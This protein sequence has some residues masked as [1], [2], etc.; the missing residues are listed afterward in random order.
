M[1]ATDIY[2]LLVKEYGLTRSWEDY[3]AHYRELAQIIYGERSNLIGKVAEIIQELNTTGHTVGLASSSPRSWIDIVV[4]RFAL[5]DQFRAIVSSEDVGGTGKP[6][7]DI[8][9]HCIE[10][11]GHGISTPP[12]AIEDTDKGIRSAKSAGCHVFG[13]R[14]GFNPKQSL[15]EA[16]EILTGWGT[17]SIYLLKRTLEEC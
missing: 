8:Y 6:A 7:P 9:L 13:F 4:D 5:R 10:L 14:N 12:V 11:L 1:S 16:D 3:I 17:E 2:K 15:A